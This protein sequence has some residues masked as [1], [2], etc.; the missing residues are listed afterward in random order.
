M[1]PAVFLDRDGVLIEKID[2]D[3]VR[4]KSQIKL[5]PFVNEAITRL[6]IRG[7]EIVIVTNQACVGKGFI[8]IDDA[9]SIQNEVVNLLDPGVNLNIKSE[10]CP[11]LSNE[12][13]ECRKPQPGMILAAQ[14]KYQLDLSKSYLVGDAISDIQA[15]ITAGVKPIFVLTGRGKLSELNSIDVT[16][17]AVDD[18]ND[19]AEYI[20]GGQW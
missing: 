7:Y 17:K 16:V 3:Y 12:G 15:S 10:L 5:L 2:G 14:K 20:L 11:H 19:A 6:S 4:D 8:S 18:I 13:C 9:W 1:K